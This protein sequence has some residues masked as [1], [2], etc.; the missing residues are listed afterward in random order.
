VGYT[1]DVKA[2]LDVP[3]PLSADEIADL[4]LHVSDLLDP[5]APDP[6][7]AGSS[8]ISTAGSPSSA[9]ARARRWRIPSE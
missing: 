9:V 5:V 2:M 8:R 6:P 3:R 4:I 7:F 1:I